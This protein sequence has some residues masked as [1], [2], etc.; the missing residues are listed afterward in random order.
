MEILNEK[1]KVLLGK[2]SNYL[3]A[4][5]MKNGLIDFSVEDDDIN[6]DNVTN[7]SNNWSVEVPEWILPTIKKVIDFC[8]KRIEYLENYSYNT[9][10]IDIDA[11]RKEITANQS[12]GYYELGDDQ[13][14]EWDMER[15]SEDITSLFDEIQT[16]G[17]IS[18]F[19]ELRYDGSGDS[20]YIEDEFTDGTDVPPSVMDW[21]YR[22]L[23]NLH[24]GWEINE[25][26]SG[27]F[28]FDLQ[29][30]K[31]I[32]NHNYN[33]EQQDSV[34]FYETTFGKTN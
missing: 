21:C 18:D 23:E 14:T 34:T 31:I 1:D 7:F 28:E 12:W 20:G 10:E 19:L 26:S 15:D 3:R 25:G 13:V 11:V 6:I 2:L 33:E 24:G 8:K 9:F 16:Q 4:S 5:G 17:E 30:K 22:E 27:R 29:N 32:L